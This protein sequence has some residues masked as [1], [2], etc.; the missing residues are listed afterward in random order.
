MSTEVPPVLCNRAAG[1][2]YFPCDLRFGVDLS[3]SNE[4][5]ACLKR[6]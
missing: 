4:E 6:N 5:I 2:D 3:A 1:K